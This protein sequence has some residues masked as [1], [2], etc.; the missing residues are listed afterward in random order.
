MIEIIE[1]DKETYSGKNFTMRYQTKG[2]Y[3]IQP[4]ESGFNIC[5]KTFAKPK[6]MSFG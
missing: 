4:K 3:D 5:Y 6:E 1:L 2:Y